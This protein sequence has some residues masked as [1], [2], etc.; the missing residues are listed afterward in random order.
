MEV[1][2]ILRGH[3]GWSVEGIRMVGLWECWVCAEFIY[4][5]RL[6][7]GTLGKLGCVLRVRKSEGI[8]YFLVP[9]SNNVPIELLECS[10]GLAR[11]VFEHWGCCWCQKKTMITIWEM[12]GEIWSTKSHPYHV[13]VVLYIN[14]L[15]Q[16]VTWNIC[17]CGNI[18][19]LWNYLLFVGYPQL[20]N[21][22]VLNM[23]II[24]LKC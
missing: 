19:R 9:M 3:K 17:L 7:L 4:R 2:K 1:M 14:W 11:A 21:R 5:K 22:I 24:C 8:K 16:L 12:S 6:R 23:I 13:V 10:C 18:G 15:G 20:S